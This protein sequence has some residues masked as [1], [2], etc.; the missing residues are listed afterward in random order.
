MDER[1]LEMIK[2]EAERVAGQVGGS[3]GFSLSY[4]RKR[5]AEALELVA[6]IERLNGRLEAVC[7]IVSDA[8]A[9]GEDISALRVLEAVRG[10]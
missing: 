8:C 10:R 7:A 5:A 3:G 1:R 2:E 4:G 9:F 6:E